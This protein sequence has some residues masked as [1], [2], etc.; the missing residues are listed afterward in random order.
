MAAIFLVCSGLAVWFGDSDP[1]K[2]FLLLM[3][4]TVFLFFSLALPHEPLRE[5][6][7]LDPVSIYWVDRTVLPGALLAA[8]LLARLASQKRTNSS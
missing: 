4:W 2:R 3:F 7:H 8:M 1:T 5:E 6:V